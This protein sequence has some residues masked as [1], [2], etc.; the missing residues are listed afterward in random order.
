M[1]NGFNFGNAYV[2]NMSPPTPNLEIIHPYIL[3]YRSEYRTIYK[4][5]VYKA[6]NLFFKSSRGA[7]RKIKLRRN[8]F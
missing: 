3:K 4:S 6:N 8:K 7:P 1:E 5:E 2:N